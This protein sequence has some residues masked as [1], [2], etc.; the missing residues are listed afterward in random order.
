MSTAVSPGGRRRQARPWADGRGRTA[1][2]RCVS[3]TVHKN[4]TDMAGSSAL[5]VKVVWRSTAS[6]SAPRGIKQNAATDHTP[7]IIKPAPMAARSGT[8]SSAY[9]GAT[10]NVANKQKLPA[11]SMR[12]LPRAVGGQESQQGGRG[13]Q[14]GEH[15]DGLAS[16][17][18]GQIAGRHR[19]DAAR[20]QV[21][22]QH[23]AGVAFGEAFGNVVQR[24][25]AA[26]GHLPYGSNQRGHG[27]VEQRRDGRRDRP[28]RCFG[29]APERRDVP[30]LRL[31]Q[32]HAETVHRRPRQVQP[33]KP[34]SI[35]TPATP[36]AG[37]RSQSVPRSPH[38]PT[39]PVTVSG[40]SAMPMVP[41]TPK[42]DI[43]PA[44]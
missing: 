20:H 10:E 31:R 16:P 27:Q 8:S 7:P 41:P 33:V 5:T 42:I 3:G 25:E 30:A 29:V 34:R 18:V 28:S 22:R 38:V 21:H 2:R 15:D 37:T 26:H 4:T 19:A 24:Q 17:P 36:S 14:S 44:L 13:Q 43:A 6:A 9:T 40:T 35:N 39:S 12:R 1:D 23:H 32:R 11:T